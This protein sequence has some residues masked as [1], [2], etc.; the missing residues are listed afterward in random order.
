L[1]DMREN[2]YE[3]IDR[4]ISKQMRSYHLIL[5]DT[6][7]GKTAFCINYFYK[8]RSNKKRVCLISLASSGFSTH[9][10][11]ITKKQ[12][13]ILILDAFDE[14]AA[15]KEDGHN[16]F[17]NLLKQCEDFKSVIITCRSQY[18]QGEDFIPRETPLP[19]INPKSL[20]ASGNF[21][22]VRSYISPF[23]EREISKYID[24][25]FPIWNL[26]TLGARKKARHLAAEVPDLAYRPMLLEHL[27]ELVTN[28]DWSNE[29]YDLYS[30]LVEGWLDRE[31]KWI[32]P[33]ELLRASFEIA[34]NFTCVEMTDRL[35]KGRIHNIVEKA[36][37]VSP[38]WQHLSTR[39][40]LNCDSKGR[41]KF[42]H[43][44]ILEYLL[45]RMAVDGDFRSLETKWTPFM[46]ELLVSWGHKNDDAGS[47]ETARAILSD[48]R[49]HKNLYPLY[50][51]WLG[52]NAFPTLNFDALLARRESADG[53]RLAPLPWRQEGLTVVEK[54]EMWMI[55]DNEFNI[56]WRVIKD[57]MHE[58]RILSLSIKDIERIVSND[59]NLRFPYLDE[60]VSLLDGLKISGNDIINYGDVFILEDKIGAKDKILLAIGDELKGQPGVKQ[61]ERTRTIR[62][63]GYRVG[64]FVTGISYS[65]RYHRRK[66]RQLYVENR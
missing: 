16:L 11:S 59:S 29:I 32:E 62:S 52:T 14:Y 36:F 10:K 4:S 57:E 56:S 18:F 15:D 2:I 40:L 63:D 49:S 28:K 61:I 43:R 12:D 37:G 54:S 27:P 19:N 23:D 8:L 35:S 48:P 20:N 5:A 41:Y 42:A 44:S 50:D 53:Q 66:V 7:M 17:E 3:Y 21:S 30:I 65:N 46:K 26:R 13:C 47:V 31:K 58:D 55:R 38:A 25:H 22:L 34:Y 64:L 39:S 51:I 33:C 24:K 6:G 1:A 45:V 60:I 9:I